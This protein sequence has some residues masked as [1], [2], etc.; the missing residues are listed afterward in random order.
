[1]LVRRDAVFTGIEALPERALGLLDVLGEPQLVAD[2]GGVAVPA[3]GPSSNLVHVDRRSLA[4][5]FLDRARERGAVVTEVGRLPPASSLSAAAV[6]DATGRAAAW[7]RPLVT[8]GHAVAWQFEGAPQAD[9]GLRMVQGDRWWAYRLATPTSTWAGVVAAGGAVSTS[10][11]EGPDTGAALTRLGLDPAEMVPRGRRAARV[12][13][14]VHP[15]RGRRIAV[16][17]AALAH[18]P[19]AGA[20]IRFALASAI[21]AATTIATWL[22]DPDR[23]DL[24]AGYY[25]DLVV[26]EHLRHLEARR[27]IHAD[28][29]RDAPLDTEP[30]PDVLPVP[31]VV[32]FSATVV[33]APLAVDGLIRPGEAVRLPDGTLTRW[34]GSFDL[35]VLARLASHPVS[36]VLLLARLQQEGLGRAAARRVL[37]WA[38]RHG[39]LTG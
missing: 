35:L 8:D 1:M 20:G 24:A 37:E 2:A 31:A 30:V 23:H 14:A 29:G 32:R 27:S 15:V 36:R 19:V 16:G 28:G 10:D 13:R 9:A 21:A 12:Q 17:D 11:D 6:V 25:T 38:T 39:L 18:D 7:S 22:D 34:L 3:D 5:V 4:A 26:G 33:E